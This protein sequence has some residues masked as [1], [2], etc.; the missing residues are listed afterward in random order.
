[1]FLRF[2]KIPS[3]LYAPP[4]G[5]I[6]A[7]AIE[8]KSLSKDDI[9]DYLGDDKEETEPI[10]L[11]DD[12]TEKKADKADKDEKEVKEPEKE[13]KE[14]IEEPEDE[15]KEIEE[16]L[17]EV[18]PD[19]EKFELVTPARRRDILKKYP[20]LFKD[21]PYLEKAYYREQAFT[22]VFPTIADAKDAQEKV[23]ILDNF[24]RDMMT[25]DTERL[26][27]G[28]KQSDPKAFYKI[29]DNYLPVLAKVDEKAY[30]HVAGN[31][32]K[33]T[34]IAMANEAKTSNN[35]DLQEAAHLLNQFVFGSSNFTAP[36]TLVTEEPEDNRAKEVEEREQRIVQREFDR[37]NTDL[38]SRLDN[39][40]KATINVNIDP[41]DTMTEYVK[42]NA[43]REAL[44]DV[45]KL[46]EQDSRFKILLDRLWDNAIKNDF[47]KAAVERIYDAYISKA[48]TLLPSVI[49]KA[50]NEA[51]KGMGK[52]VSDDKE[53]KSSD[54]SET[55]R[56]ESRHSSM[57]KDKGG[58]PAGMTT[59][60]FLNQ[61]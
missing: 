8:D 28:I 54:K 22:S 32:I 37:A 29:V 48:K 11:T 51:L 3:L 39:K 52:R 10:K 15:L 40:L 27:T 24:E 34:I 50:R 2:S 7:G 44:E 9:I 26:L 59:L 1:M 42:K 21:F 36:T 14:E 43:T 30:H 45:T 57:P 58:V 17:Q 20:T 35:S 49:K 53:E 33:H 46:I 18:E 19:D 31:V 23:E 16:E 4:E 5:A 38:T 55:T 12:K 60:E 13:D 25:G 61:D 47:S 6:G 56:R 41:K